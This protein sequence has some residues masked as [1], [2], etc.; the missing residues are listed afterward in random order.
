MTWHG[1]PW[2]WVGAVSAL[3]NGVVAALLAAL[4]WR[5]YRLEKARDESRLEATGFRL[6]S[7]QYDLFLVNRGNAPVSIETVRVELLKPPQGNVQREMRFWRQ[8]GPSGSPPI[9]GAELAVY[10]LEFIRGIP[11]GTDLS[12]VRVHVRDVL[13]RTITRDFDGDWTAGPPQDIA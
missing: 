9:R 4:T 2:N 3:V 7:S 10:K 6:V 1:N 13:G 12:R 5:L 8:D 11:E